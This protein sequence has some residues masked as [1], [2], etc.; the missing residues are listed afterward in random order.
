MK[1]Y[2]VVTK[3]KIDIPDSKVKIVKKK[4]RY[5][6]VGDYLAYDPKTKKKKKYQAWR[7]LSKEQA[8]KMK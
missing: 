5:F 4:G 8:M 1:F 6:A 7:V 3:K 2:S